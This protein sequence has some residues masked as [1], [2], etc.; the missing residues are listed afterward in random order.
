MVC[1]K[2]ASTGGDPR[3]VANTMQEYVQAKD[4]DIRA[5]LNFPMAQLRTVLEA[6]AAGRMAPAGASRVIDCAFLQSMPPAAAGGGGGVGVGGAGGGA[7]GQQQQQQQLQQV[8]PPPPRQQ[9]QQQYQ[10]QQQQ[11]QQRG[12]PFGGGVPA[13][14]P[15]AFGGARPAT[16]GRACH[17]FPPK[18]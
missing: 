17:I 15:G 14:T 6:A 10:P 1:G 16:P 12:S 18:S 13:A 4:N 11:Q 3:A 8:P 2:V 5:I 7:F 9:Q